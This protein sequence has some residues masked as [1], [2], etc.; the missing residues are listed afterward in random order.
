MSQIWILICKLIHLKKNENI[1][2]TLKT[3]IYEAGQLL[4]DQFFNMIILVSH[5]EGWSVNV[6]VTN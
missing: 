5:L 3:V 1:G 2:I 4:S 6:L